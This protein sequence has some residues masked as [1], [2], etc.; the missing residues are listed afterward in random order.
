MDAALERAR[1]AVLALDDAQSRAALA[2]AEQ[3]FGCGPWASADQVG[4]LWLI[5]GARAALSG[6]D[7]EALDA[8]AGAARLA[9]DLW[10]EDLGPELRARYEEARGR[11]GVAPGEIRVSPDPQELEVWLDGQQVSVPRLSPGGLHVLQVGPPGGPAVF[12]RVFWLPA[13]E[14]LV[15]ESGLAPDLGRRLAEQA[16]AAK[17]ALAAARTPA[18]EAEITEVRRKAARAWG[19]IESA[20]RGTDER[21]ERLLSDYVKRFG[22]VSVSSSAGPIPVD[23]PQAR[24]ARARLAALPAA[25]AKVAEARASE[26]QLEAE[27]GNR[28]AAGI[29]DDQAATGLLRQLDLGVGG[30]WTRAGDMAEGGDAFSGLGPRVGLGLGLRLTPALGLRAEIGGATVGAAPASATAEL[31][32]EPSGTSLTLGYGALCATWSRGPLELQAGGL[33]ALGGGQV[34]AASAFEDPAALGLPAEAPTTAAVR[35]GGLTL[36]AGYTALYLGKLRIGPELRLSALSDLD[37]TWA[38]G[39]LG[40]RAAFRP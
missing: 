40:L 30:A 16:A 7:Q 28:R 38:Q 15:I 14:L 37:R 36:G 3:A 25:R 5:E 19:E 33:Y 32:V 23:I 12:A 8:F 6:R 39:E 35:A 9:P 31:G 20:T 27:L 11:A 34:G 18:V 21:A 24:E 17:A 2:E 1:Q 29:A 22:E 4:R 10:D 26:A 13:D